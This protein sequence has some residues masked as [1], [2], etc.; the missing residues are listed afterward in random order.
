MGTCLVGVAKWRF[1]QPPRPPRQSTKSAPPSSDISWIIF[2][3]SGSRKKRSGRHGDKKIVRALAVELAAGAVAAVLRNE[4]ALV[5]EGKQGVASGIDAKDDAS[6]LSAVAAVGA[7]VR[8]VFFTSEGN[9]AVA[10]VSG[11]T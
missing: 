4:F 2:S 3:V 11:F 8:D 10:A 7:A 5:A 9:G 1:P 6:A